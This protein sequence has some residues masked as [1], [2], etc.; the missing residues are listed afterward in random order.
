MN[1]TDLI[2]QASL[3]SDV[4]DFA[5]GDTLKVHVRVVEGNKQRV[6]VFQGVVIRRQG[7]GVQETFT[8]RKLSYGVGVERTFPLHSPIIEK[9]EVYTRGDVRRAKLYYLRDRIGKAAKVKEKRDF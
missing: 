3:R 9:I 2:D 5:P 8:V 7:G 4:P 6:Q 1:R